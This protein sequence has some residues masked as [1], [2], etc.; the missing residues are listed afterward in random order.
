MAEHT[1]KMQSEQ[2]KTTVEV[3]KEQ[4][5]LN[6]AIQAERNELNAGFR[7]LDRDRLELHRQR[8]SELAWAE[9]FQFLAIVIAA[10]MPLFF[11][12]YLIWSTNRSTSNP[13]VVNELLLQELVSPAPRLIAGPN[14]RLLESQVNSNSEQNESEEHTETTIN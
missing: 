13:Q 11:C 3:N 4:A 5:A 8:R 7:Q 9:A 12:V 1:V 2:N 14:H 6:E 10:S